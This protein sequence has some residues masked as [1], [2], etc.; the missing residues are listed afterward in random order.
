MNGWI[1][2]FLKIFEPRNSSIVSTKKKLSE[3]KK[4]ERTKLE[5]ALKEA[6]LR[7]RRMRGM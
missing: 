2:N 4:A 1:G 6:R 3:R 7:V 5:N